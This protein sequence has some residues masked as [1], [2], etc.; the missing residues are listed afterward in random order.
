MKSNST[1]KAI[2][3]EIS[4]LPANRSMENL[5]FISVI[6]ERM[7]N[8]SGSI[9]KYLENQ[10]KRFIYDELLHNC[11]LINPTEKNGKL[12]V[13]AVLKHD[14]IEN[15]KFITSY[16]TGSEDAAGVWRKFMGLGNL[17]LDDNRQL[18]LK[19]INF[20]INDSIVEPT[21]ADLELLDD[22][23]SQGIDCSA[24]DSDGPAFIE[25]FPEYSLWRITAKAT[26]PEQRRHAMIIYRNIFMKNYDGEDTRSLHSVYFPFQKIYNTTDAGSPSGLEVLQDRASNELFGREGYVNERESVAQKCDEATANLGIVRND[27]FQGDGRFPKDFILGNK[28][29]VSYN[30]ALNLPLNVTH[31]FENNNNNYL[32]VNQ[33]IKSNNLRLQRYIDILNKCKVLYKYLLNDFRRSEGSKYYDLSTGQ[34]NVKGI[35]QEKYQFLKGFIKGAETTAQAELDGMQTLY[36]ELKH[37]FN[38][39]NKFISDKKKKIKKKE[40]GTMIKED[41]NKVLEAGITPS[42]SVLDVTAVTPVNLISF[43]DTELG[44]FLAKGMDNFLHPY[45]KEGGPGE[46]NNDE[47]QYKTIQTSPFYAGATWKTPISDK[48]KDAYENLKLFQCLKKVFPTGIAETNFAKNSGKNYKSMPKSAIAVKR[49]AANI[50]LQF[51]REFLETNYTPEEICPPGEDEEGGAGKGEEEEDEEEEEEE[52]LPNSVLFKLLY[53]LFCF[54]FEAPQPEYYGFLGWR[55]TGYLDETNPLM[56]RKIQ[57]S[58]TF[59]ENAIDKTI[60]IINDINSEYGEQTITYSYGEKKLSLSQ[61]VMSATQAMREMRQMMIYYLAKYTADGIIQAD[62]DK[63]KKNNFEF[64][65]I[66]NRKAIDSKENQLLVNNLTE[67]FIIETTATPTTEPLKGLLNCPLISQ[68]I[69]KLVDEA[70]DINKF[71]IS[72]LILNHKTQADEMQIHF[73]KMS[74]MLYYEDNTD[75]GNPNIHHL[76]SFDGFAIIKLLRL[77]AGGLYQKTRGCCV[78]FHNKIG[79]EDSFFNRHFRGKEKVY[80]NEEFILLDVDNTMSSAYTTP[81]P[82]PTSS[83]S[84]APGPTTSSSSSSSSSSSAPEPAPAP[85]TSKHITHTDII[86]MNEWFEENLKFQFTSMEALVKK[87]MSPTEKELRQDYKR[88]ITSYNNAINCIYDI[89]ALMRVEKLTVDQARAREAQQKGHFETLIKNIGADSALA[90]FCK[91]QGIKDTY[92]FISDEHKEN[93]YKNLESLINVLTQTENE[94]NRVGEW[95][96]QNQIQLT[97]IGLVKRKLIEENKSDVDDV[98]SISCVKVLLKFME[99]NL[100]KEIDVNMEVTRSPPKTPAPGRQRSR[101]NSKTQKREGDDIKFY[102]Y[103]DY[104]MVQI[105]KKFKTTLLQ[106]N[107]LEDLSDIL[108]NR[109]KNTIRSIKISFS[110]IKEDVNNSSSFHSQMFQKGVKKLML[111]VDK[112]ITEE[113]QEDDVIM[114]EPG[115]AKGEEGVAQET[116][117]M[118][119]E[120]ETIQRLIS[121]IAESGI[122]S[123]I[124]RGQL[125]DA[126]DSIKLFSISATAQTDGKS[127]THTKRGA[128][129]AT[130]NKSDEPVMKKR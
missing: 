98:N 46:V 121:E 28:K 31:L 80:K 74:K 63:I 111:S 81:P 15:L 76:Y 23:K 118:K 55:T 122:L 107:T 20:P 36:M 70:A 11:L 104:R 78:G 100:T 39:T 12:Q 2:R 99:I 94:I 67:R 8:K 62:W 41:G 35:I 89:F 52:E 84:S 10:L 13:E 3:A 4:S 115:A 58:S 117:K 72:G 45:L 34:L 103:L 96:T 40:D 57:Y 120:I 50:K 87:S 109:M 130:T 37:L 88:E 18:I 29:T 43:Y 116:T 126:L 32:L 77:G 82:S 102:L 59:V 19:T 51:L 16:E 66:S 56:R 69:K 128:T 119:I 71:V 53:N 92:T 44:G 48:N 90:D 97:L 83:L 5:F 112:K 125:T 110:T 17:S 113:G 61:S 123:D 105:N 106:I 54:D 24:L 38:I 124:D 114:V 7:S 95:Q 91:A 9:G 27:N 85:A 101:S 127:E 30:K 65:V 22:C 1:L 47:A 93:I 14:Y 21:Y 33:K 73:E 129:P 6:Y 49:V 60:D 108:V 42:V 25:K 64:L 75:T 26:T 68:R 79:G 86:N